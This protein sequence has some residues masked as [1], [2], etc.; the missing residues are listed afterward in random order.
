MDA[1]THL[2]VTVGEYLELPIDKI[3]RDVNVH[4][5]ARLRRNVST[6]ED[7]IHLLL[8]HPPRVQLYD[9]GLAVVDGTHRQAVGRSLQF[10]TQ[11][12][13]KEIV[14]VVMPRVSTVFSRL[15][16]WTALPPS[17]WRIDATLSVM[18]LAV[19]LLKS[20]SHLK[21]VRR[22]SGHTQAV[23]ALR[24]EIPSSDFVSSTTMYVAPRNYLL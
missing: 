21:L 3:L 16:A 23:S 8:D 6:I 10:S 22:C 15:A 12:L 18:D 2:S 13:K 7:F 20:G 24:K 9:D 1:K 11:D 14:I 19:S 4:R 17:D 5:L